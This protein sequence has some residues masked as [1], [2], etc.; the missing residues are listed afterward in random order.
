MI[1]YLIPGNAAQARV[2]GGALSQITGGTRNKRNPIAFR[3]LWD[4]DYVSFPIGWRD[5]AMIRPMK[6]GGIAVKLTGDAD[7]SAAINGLGDAASGLTGSA[8]VSVAAYGLTALK[9]AAANVT[10]AG[11]ISA[12]INGRGQ[13]AAT[14]NVSQLTDSDVNG[15]V[16]DAL[17]E[18]GITLKEALRLLLA[19]AVGKTDINTGGPNPIVT[20]RDTADTTDRVTAT[21]TGSE[22]TSVTLDPD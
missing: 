7:V 8:S 6:D 11:S 9:Q 13:M 10:G 5:G 21:M 18:N 3:T 20:F 22:R 1:N 16:L 15:A 14:I 4:N 12:S 2:F 17:I 19:V